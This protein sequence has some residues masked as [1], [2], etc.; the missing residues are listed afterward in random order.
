MKS[1]EPDDLID[2]EG[3]L[4]YLPSDGEVA[5]GPSRRV[6]LSKEHLTSS[7]SKLSSSNVT[8]TTCNMHSCQCCHC[9][10]LVPV[11]KLWKKKWRNSKKRTR[12]P[13]PQPTKG[14]GDYRKVPPAGSGAEP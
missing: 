6:T 11:L 13:P 3:T 5:L 12:C 1:D 4:Q 10:V 9:V 2:D 8:D 14:S 7:S